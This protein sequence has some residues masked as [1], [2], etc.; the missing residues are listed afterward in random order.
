MLIQPRKTNWGY[1]LII[2]VLAGLVSGGSF[3]FTKKIFEG[4]QT[5]DI[6]FVDNS[7]INNQKE[8]NNIQSEYKLKNSLEDEFKFCKEAET[9]FEKEDCYFYLALIIEERKICDNILTDSY[10][11]H[12]KAVLSKDFKECDKIDTKDEKIFC[13][14]VVERDLE[15][16]SEDNIDDCSFSLTLHNSLLDKNSSLCDIMPDINQ[17]YNKDV[18]FEV[19]NDLMESYFDIKIKN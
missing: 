11:Y 5:K 19:Y 12:C 6:V 7:K 8:I 3:Y 14:A 2:L 16:C 18:C 15:M 1:I 13:K 9:N 4:K 10:Q 17:D